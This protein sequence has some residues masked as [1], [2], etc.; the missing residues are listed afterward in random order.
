[1]D[2]LLKRIQDPANGV[3]IEDRRYHLKIYPQT[4]VGR[5][6]VD[7][8]VANKIFGCRKDAVEF[9]KVLVERGVIQHCTQG[10]ITRLKKE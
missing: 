2:D 1:M 9:G 5:E 10:N 4:F 6:L 3:S 7:W 8:F